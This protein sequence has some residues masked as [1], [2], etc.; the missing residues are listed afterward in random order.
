MKV[1]RYIISNRFLEVHIADLGATIMKIVVKDVDAQ[2][3]DI[4]LGFDD[5]DQYASADYLSN[6]PYFGAMMGRCAG[7][8]GNA[9][10]E[11]D[12]VHYALSANVAPHHLHGGFYKFK[13]RQLRRRLFP[14]LHTAG[15]IILPR[16]CHNEQIA[17]KFF[18]AHIFRKS[19]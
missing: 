14:V 18:K 3:V 16:L 6:Y 4:V 13:H 9:S 7:R 2:P 19:G 15:E 12:G 5:A 10:F 11:V 1:N 17:G 8:I